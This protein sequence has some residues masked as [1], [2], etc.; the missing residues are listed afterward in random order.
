M[1]THQKPERLILVDGHAVAFDS[2]FSSGEEDVL[3]RSSEPKRLQEARRA[4]RAARGAV[5]I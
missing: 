3:V 2:W 4:G 5:A 1:N